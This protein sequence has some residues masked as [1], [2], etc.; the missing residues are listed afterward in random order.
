MKAVFKMGVKKWYN[1]HF[2]NC[3]SWHEGTPNI[4]S[5]LSTT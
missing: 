5:G 1:H 3:H 4:T 2:Y